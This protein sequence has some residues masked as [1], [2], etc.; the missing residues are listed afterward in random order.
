MIAFKLEG[1]KPDFFDFKRKT[2]IFLI[3]TAPLL[4][5]MVGAVVEYQYSSFYKY[6]NY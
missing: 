2:I 4:K 3:A 6:C 1:D 5:N